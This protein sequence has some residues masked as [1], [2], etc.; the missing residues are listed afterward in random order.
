MQEEHI[1]LFELNSLIK[2]SL[3][4]AFPDSYW[5]IAEI[6]ELKV[7]YSGHCYLEL[8]EKNTNSETLKA[9]AR[10]T[11]WS[12]VFRMIQPY[13]ETTTR[14]KLAA[15][16]KIMVKATVEFH[17]LYGLSLNITDIEPRFTLGELA[18]R[19]QEVIDRLKAEGVFELNKQQILPRL[20]KTI[21]VISSETAAG[22]GDF[23]NQLL[24][25]PYGYAF[26]L[27]LFPAVMQG[28]EAEVS[29]V[30]AMESV[31]RYEDF[32]DALVIIRG[33]G[34]QSDLSCFNGYWI[35]SHIAQFSLPVLTGIGHEQDETIADMVAHTRLK[36]PTAV[37]E[38]LLARFQ[39]EEAFQQELS[40]SMVEVSRDIILTQ[41][42]RLMKLALTIKPLVLS[43]VE[44]NRKRLAIASVM[45]ENTSSAVVSGFMNKIALM[46]FRV[47][48]SSKQYFR[49]LGH[50]VLMIKKNLMNVIPAYMTQQMFRTGVLANKVHY[51]D[52]VNVLKRGYSIT[53]FQGKPIKNAGEVK[54]GDT[55]DT[56][57]HEGKL[58]ST[59][60]E[61][62]QTN[63]SDNN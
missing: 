46:Q 24:C 15:G 25:N 2:G 27:R 6:S 37:A 43:L 63:P 48:S 41:N 58:T 47:L 1:T 53:L 28:D 44:G 50:M 36:T 13:F 10:A 21:A 17:E 33:G 9:K 31:F 7:N 19:K 11:I 61:K 39:E 34:A 18:R 40:S 20:P 57:L 3:K 8:V 30:S 60:I 16:L 56:M 45:I 23:R 29:I 55:V 22:Y 54:E 49:D 52:P 59:I 14:T 38:F 12:S 26:Y 32:F 5:I 42:N 4:K 35:A 62:S 51:N